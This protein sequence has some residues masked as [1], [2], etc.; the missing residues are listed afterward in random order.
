MS[1]KLIEDLKCPRCQSFNVIMKD[2]KELYCHDCEYSLQTNA[3]FENGISESV[4]IQIKDFISNKQL[5]FAIKLY[6]ETMNVDLAFAQ[7]AI[8]KINKKYN[9]SKKNM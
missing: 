3:N 9:L 4:L 8:E 6:W 7:Y 5:L 2:N 1:I